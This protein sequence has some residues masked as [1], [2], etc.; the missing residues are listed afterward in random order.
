MFFYELLYKMSA[1]YIIQAKQLLETKSVY[2]YLDPVTS[3]VGYSFLESK[4][5]KAIALYTKAISQCYIEKNYISIVECYKEIAHLQAKPIIYLETLK[6]AVDVAILHNWNI[7]GELAE[8]VIARHSYL[9]NPKLL[10]RFY[11]VCADYYWKQTLYK[12]CINMLTQITIIYQTECP[13]AC[14]P[15]YENIIYIYLTKLNKPNLA[16]VFCNGLILLFCKDPDK[17]R[18]YADLIHAIETNSDTLKKFIAELKYIPIIK[19]YG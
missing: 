6:A 7:A 13:L 10:L 18:F 3:I 2:E 19:T 5:K 17:Q 14:E 4:I 8:S 12:E 11:E 16:S 1:E 15:V 9:N